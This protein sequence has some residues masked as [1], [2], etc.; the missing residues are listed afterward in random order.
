M[1][2]YPPTLFTYLTLFPLS[3]LHPIHSGRQTAAGERRPGARIHPTLT[4]VFQPFYGA[5]H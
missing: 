1:S 4:R 2:P 3:T 5:I